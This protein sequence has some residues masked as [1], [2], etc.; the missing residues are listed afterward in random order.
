[1]V[2]VVVVVVVVV[3]LVVVAVVVVWS[4]CG[5]GDSD[6]SGAIWTVPLQSEHIM[7]VNF[8]ANKPLCSLIRECFAECNKRDVMCMTLCVCAEGI[9]ATWSKLECAEWEFSSPNDN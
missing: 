3:M 7:Y 4:W 2:V 8:N 6:R 1:L 9:R 5:R